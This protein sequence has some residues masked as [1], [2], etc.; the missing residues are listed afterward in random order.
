[1]SIVLAKH[2]IGVTQHPSTIINSKSRRAPAFARARDVY[3]GIEVGG[4]NWRK[5]LLRLSHTL[6]WYPHRDEGV[7]HP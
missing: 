2:L 3:T 6:I 7:A 5:S 4:S 1:M